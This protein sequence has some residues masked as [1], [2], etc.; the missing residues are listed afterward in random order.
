[1]NK[2]LYLCHLLVL[3]SATLMMPGHTNMKFGR[4]EFF[5]W[6][7]GGSERKRQLG[8]TERHWED[9]NDGKE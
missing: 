8:V 4:T 9:R 2:H 7:G 3:S 1:V 5:L 6:G